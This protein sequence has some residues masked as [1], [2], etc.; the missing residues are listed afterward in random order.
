MSLPNINNSSIMDNIVCVDVVNIDN[1]SQ[2]YQLNFLANGGIKN[3]GVLRNCSFGLGYSGPGVNEQFDY[4]ISDDSII[5]NSIFG[6]NRLDSVLLNG[7]M[8]NSSL[9]IHRIMGAC[10]M[11]GSMFLT[12]I[13]NSGDTYGVSYNLKSFS[14]RIP[15]K[16]DFGYIYD[17]NETF[18][19]KTVYN[20]TQ[21]KRLIYNVITSGLTFS[22]VTVSTAQ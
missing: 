17:F 13:K 14:D 9:I 11:S 8:I 16:T 18:N 1:K 7:L 5:V 3:N 4:T 21:D 10:N 19:D 6:A 2:M 15:A 12:R 20:D 22:A